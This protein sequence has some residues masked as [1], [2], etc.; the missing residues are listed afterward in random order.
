MK[1]QLIKTK[2]TLYTN[3]N[4]KKSFNK[5]TL[6][7]I[8]LASFLISTSTSISAEHSQIYASIFDESIYD[9]SAVRTAVGPDRFMAPEDDK[10][11]HQ[12]I[13]QLFLKKIYLLEK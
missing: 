7:I 6:S 3:K 11:D 13:E 1:Q 5:F 2:N 12:I 8:G 10:V 9:Q 4:N